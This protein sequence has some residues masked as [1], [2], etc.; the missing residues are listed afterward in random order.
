[1]DGKPRAPPGSPN[2]G[3][4]S[5]AFAINVH[6]LCPPGAVVYVAE[7]QAR[8][9]MIGCDAADD[10]RNAS[11]ASPVSTARAAFGYSLL[12]V[13]GMPNGKSARSG[14][15]GTT[16]DRN[17]GVRSTP[18]SGRT[19]VRRASRPTACAAPITTNISVN[20]RSAGSARCRSF[21]ARADRLDREN[22]RQ[23]RRSAG[24]SREGDRV[25]AQGAASRAAN[26]GSA[27]WARRSAA[28]KRMGL[29]ALYLD[30]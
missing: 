1:M 19:M 7:D 24:T 8:P 15:D 23:C 18:R 20:S 14:A 22:R 21:R 9:L 17:A 10:H 16:Q 12:D 13:G 26:A 11:R 28:S 3:K 4:K 27:A 30:H 5:A 2:A 6:D 25:V 29:R